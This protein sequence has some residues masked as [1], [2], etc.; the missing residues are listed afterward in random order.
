MRRT[1]LVMTALVVCAAAIGFAA[2][3]SARGTAA[4]TPAQSSRE[5]TAAAEIAALRTTA[6]DLRESLSETYLNS[7]Y[8]DYADSVVREP[9]GDIKLA[10]DGNGVAFVALLSA[11]STDP[12]SVTVD[13]WS[14]VPGN[15]LPRYRNRVR[16][17]QTLPIRDALISVVLPEGANIAMPYGT[18]RT[19]GGDSDFGM[20]TMMTFKEFA[21]AAE[22]NPELLKGPYS[23]VADS[24][25][26]YELH[27]WPTE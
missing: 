6:S 15:G 8:A 22:R 17:L 11:A 3:V 23:V 25:G 26:V 20:D 19:Q 7:A 12:L 9:A 5:T 1:W 24:E 14:A 27:P 10:G 4:P 21:A 18:E 13:V 16:H 2:G